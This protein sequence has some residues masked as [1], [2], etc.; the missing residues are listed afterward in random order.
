MNV[1]IVLHLF[2]LIILERQPQPCKTEFNNARNV[3]RVGH[4]RG[5]QAASHGGPNDAQVQSTQRTIV[6]EHGGM[7][8]TNAG[9]DAIA[10]QEDMSPAAQP[11][12]AVAPPAF[13]PGCDASADMDAPDFDTSVLNSSQDA[14]HA[15]LPTP[16]LHAKS[17]RS[18]SATRLSPP[19]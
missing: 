15:R 14:D 8:I 16:D 6:C 7:A 17:P 13:P 2:T 10:Q 1:D 12:A 19:C 11:S 9:L 5:I 18:S 4:E 3:Q